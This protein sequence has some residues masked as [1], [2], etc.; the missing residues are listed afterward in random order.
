MLCLLCM[1]CSILHDPDCLNPYAVDD[2]I[3]FPVKI[4]HIGCTQVDQWIGYILPAHR[5][6]ESQ[7]VTAEQAKILTIYSGLKQNCSLLT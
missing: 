6:F 4:Q 1:R 7:P 5:W 2:T 3:L